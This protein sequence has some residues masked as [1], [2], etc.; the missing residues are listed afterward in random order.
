MKL[1]TLEIILEAAEECLSHFRIINDSGELKAKDE[2]KRLINIV[3]DQ[4]AKGKKTVGFRF[5]R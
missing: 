1:E 2:V 3:E 5:E 4:K